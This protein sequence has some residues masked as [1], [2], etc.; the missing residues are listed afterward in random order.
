METKTALQ[1]MEEGDIESCFRIL[2]TYYDKHYN[3]ALNN[4]ENLK[5]LL[6][7]IDCNSVDAKLNA[8]KINTK[9]VLAFSQLAIDGHK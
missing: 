2:L 8:D 5:S 3:K 4:R 6:T 9:E 7:N 1:K